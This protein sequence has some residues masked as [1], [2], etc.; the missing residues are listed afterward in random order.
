FRCPSSRSGFQ[1]NRTFPYVTNVSLG[2]QQEIG[3]KTVVDVAY[4]G[5]FGHNLLWRRNLN[6]IP[7]GT[8]LI[9][10]NSGLPSQ[11]FRPYLGYGDIP[12]SEYAGT[13]RYNSL[14][15]MV[16][17]RFAQRLQ[18]GVAYTLSHA[19]DYVD[20][21]TT[22]VIN[23]G[24]LGVTPRAF[25]YGRAGYDHTHVL[26]GSWTWELPKASRLWSS[27]LTRGVLDD[28]SWSGIATFQSGPPQTAVLDNVT[29]ID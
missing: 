25:N 28:W 6:A 11:F 10:A 8:T 12:Y 19:V 23:G 2:I 20:S 16:S 9:P 27:A 17:R 5:A 1:R 24:G 15:V 14:Q 21:E 18:F 7:L 29:L 22:Q 13:S 26:K 4:V 3:F